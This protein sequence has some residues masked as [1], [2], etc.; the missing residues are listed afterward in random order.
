[1]SYKCVTR[2]GCPPMVFSTNNQGAPNSGNTNMPGNLI[3]TNGLYATMITTA[4]SHRG[5]IAS[6][7]LEDKLSKNSGKKVCISTKPQTKFLSQ[8]LNRFGFKFGAP[9]GYGEPPRNTFN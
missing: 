6:G 8:N 1:M 2:G 4:F 5:R 7:N 3:T 9:Q